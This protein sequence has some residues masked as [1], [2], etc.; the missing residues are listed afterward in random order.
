MSLVSLK[1]LEGDALTIALEGRVDSGNSTVLET[2]IEKICEENSHTSLCLDVEKLVYTSSAGLR[3]FLK[4]SKRESRFSIDNACAELFEIFRVTG[5]SEVM[6]VRRALREL[7]VS[8]FPEIGRGA[9]GVV[10][11][12][13]KDTIVKV[14]NQY[15]SRTMV[16]QEKEFA[17]IAFKSEVPTA[18]SYDVVKVNNCYGVVYEMLN[19][20]DFTKAIKADI[21][22]ED[23]Y[24][25]LFAQIVKQMHETVVESGELPDYRETLKAYFRKSVG[26]L[27]SE[28]E[29]E[30]FIR[31]VD[32]VPRTKNL[33]HGDCHFGNVM[34]QDEEPV[35]IDMAGLSVGHPVFD[36]SGFYT[37]ILLFSKYCIGLVPEHLIPFD[38][39]TG[40]RIWDTFCRDYFKTEDE[41]FLEKVTD[42][43]E[44]IA[45]CRLCLA[46]VG[47]PGLFP[48]EMFKRFKQ[49]AVEYD[50]RGLSPICF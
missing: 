24:V 37:S 2:E 41:A 4:L 1:S 7:D 12:M 8:G 21:Q 42:Q 44:A 13:D 48:K 32:N 40:E 9:T 34:L 15:F 5:F 31:I 36:L 27:G 38:F 35:F 11:Q 43:V 49:R 29:V 28:T 46:A 17:L 6:T 10:Y 23:H 45:I 47:A 14:F 30:A 22:K 25:H 3:V 33:L 26:I 39:G 16:E 18:I 50:S 20:K 19:A